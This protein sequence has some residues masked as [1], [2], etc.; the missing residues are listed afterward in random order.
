MSA[1]QEAPERRADG[2]R[3][4]VFID[5]DGTLIEDVH[6]IRRPEDVRLVPGAAAALRR[7]NEAGIAVVVITNQSSIGRGMASEADYHAV[8][9][10]LDAVLA[11]EGAHVD[12]TYFCP[13]GPTDACRCRK[14]GT[15]LFERA[16]RDLGLDPARSF[17]IGDRLRDI[18]PAAELGGRGVL[19][20]S[21]DTPTMDVMRAQS[22]FK[23]ST[24][25]GAA[26]DRV[27]ASGASGA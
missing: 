15:E 19:V 23:I 21:G 27:L 11:A 22:D 26:V 12:A 25:L 4:A 2:A 7:L 20:P 6:Y 9:M 5:R 24:T 8:R 10:R 1:A 16:A 17:F 13:H 18:L 3:P 14:P